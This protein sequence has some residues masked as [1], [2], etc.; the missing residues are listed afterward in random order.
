MLV[1]ES[2]LSLKEVTPDGLDVRVYQGNQGL[3]ANI[4]PTTGVCFTVRTPSLLLRNESL[5]TAHQARQAWNG[6]EPLFRG[7]LPAVLGPCDLGDFKIHSEW[8]GG[9]PPLEVGEAMIVDGSHHQMI[10]QPLTHRVP[11]RGTAAKRRWAK[12]L[13]RVKGQP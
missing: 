9:P 6:L 1:T 2:L 13:R 11:L 3:N 7:L 12:P 5:T 4:L 10:G 8:P